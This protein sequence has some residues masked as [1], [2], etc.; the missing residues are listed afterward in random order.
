MSGDVFRYDARSAAAA[1]LGRKD[2]DLGAALAEP[3]GLQEAWERLSQ[4]ARAALVALAEL[5]GETNTSVLE[6]ELTLE[7]DDTLGDRVEAGIDDAWQS[8]LLARRLDD[9]AYYL[10]P[11]LHQALLDRLKAEDEVGSLG[12]ATIDDHC[13]GALLAA[14][15][16]IPLRL[17]RG[18]NLYKKETDQVSALVRSLLPKSQRHLIPHALSLFQKMGWLRP[19]D[20]DRLRLDGVAMQRWAEQ[21]GSLR[22]RRLLEIDDTTGRAPALFG[23]LERWPAGARIPAAKLQRLHRRAW[24]RNG[25]EAEVEHDEHGRDLALTSLLLAGLVTQDGD[26]RVSVAAQPEDDAAANDGPVAAL[27]FQVDLTVLVPRG[28]SFPALVELAR[29]CRLESADVVS[30]YVLSRERVLESL[31]DGDDD[32]ESVIQRLQGLAAAPGLPELVVQ[33][34]RGWADR[35]DEVSAHEGLILRCQP[36]DRREELEAVVARTGVPFDRLAPGLLV[37]DPA[38]H[39]EVRAALD[40]AGFQVR[41]Q[42]RRLA[43]VHE[44]TAPPAPPQFPEYDDLD[45]DWD[46]AATESPATG[47]APP[48]GILRDRLAD[49]YRR[50]FGRRT[51]EALDE[52]THD[53]L[54]RLERRGRT[55]GFLSGRESLGRADDAVEVEE[56]VD[57]EDDEELAEFGGDQSV[58]V[59]PSRARR[60]LQAAARRGQTWEVHLLTEGGGVETLEICPL[61]FPTVAEVDYV[62]GREVATKKERLVGLDQVHRLRRIQ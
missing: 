60:V 46:Q 20:A 51:L 13:L 8:G 59:S 7:L 23:L 49:K 48:P 58:A 12:T 37:L 56:T 25:I 14:A 55:R 35:F 11:E 18:G 24:S 41:R 61:D 26:E 6:D 3:D 34:L 52:L 15:A 27:R 1:A 30:R 42:P 31:E 10:E 16:T 29:W 17:T 9:D 38:H 57:D 2:G 54:I 50:E 22:R 36:D 28:T 21:P 40:Q 62:R 19:D 33:E 43:E 45:L 53:E 47:A 39:G 5:G 4:S 32:I 44:I